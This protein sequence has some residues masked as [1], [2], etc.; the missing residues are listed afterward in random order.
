M[1]EIR[2]RSEWWGGS[3]VRQPSTRAEA[4]ATVAALEAAGW[5]YSVGLSQ[6]NKRNFS[7]YGLTPATA[8]DA[9]AN[10]AATLSTIESCMA[11][12]CYDGRPTAWSP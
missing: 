2:S 12:G 6:I 9:C 7:R 1:T 3:H 8:F 10:L 4:I 5:N 11:T